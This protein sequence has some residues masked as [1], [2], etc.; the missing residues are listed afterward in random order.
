M[1]FIGEFLF[2]VCLRLRLSLCFINYTMYCLCCFQKT[3][4][5]ASVN[6]VNLNQIKYVKSNKVVVSVNDLQNQIITLKTNAKRIRSYI[7]GC[8]SELF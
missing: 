1:Q 3:T 7:S 6:A 2:Y 5:D 8:I 4:P